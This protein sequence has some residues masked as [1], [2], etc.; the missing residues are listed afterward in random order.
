M[1]SP[2]VLPDPRMEPPA[3]QADSLASEPQ[4]KPPIVL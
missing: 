1:P 3:L 4:E 2:G